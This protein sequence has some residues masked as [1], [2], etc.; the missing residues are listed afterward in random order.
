MKKLF[1]L[2]LLSIAALAHAQNLINDGGDINIAS[3]D[4]I[5]VTGYFNNVNSGSVN[6]SG[7]MEVAGNYTAAG[8]SFQTGVG[9][10]RF[11][12]TSPQTVNLTGEYSFFNMQLDNDSGLHVA[13]DMGIQNLLNFVNGKIYL[14]GHLF[15]IKN[16][17]GADSLRY[18]VCGNGGTVSN[19][20][21]SGP[22][23]DTLFYPIGFTDTTYNP[24]WFQNSGTD[25]YFSV[26]VFNDVLLQGTNGAP[27]TTD[28]HLV[29]RTWVIEEANAG[30]TVPY[31]KVQWNAAHQRPLFNASGNVGISYFIPGSTS[32]SPIAG[33]PA[34]GS[35]PYTVAQTFNPNPQS[36]TA[37]IVADENSAV[38]VNETVFN[39]LSIYPN[40]VNTGNAIQ[41][42]AKALANKNV[43][44]ALY[45]SA[46]QLVFSEKKTVPAEGFMNA[47]L[48]S[49]TSGLYLLTISDGATALY[50]GKVVVN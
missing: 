25:D 15:E 11:N 38:S 6:N 33:V 37:F 47:N 27:N 14:D 45:N 48:P 21:L 31:I 35:N 32:W 26:R 8:N 2:T 43:T 28:Q 22:G 46:G 42:N 39:D 36:M 10:Y 50:R 19:V 12:G 17:T 23:N 41:V 49:V 30:G 20:D 18:F 29:N 1:T 7:V 44:L 9:I 16:F 13:H 4:T 3:G 40:P 24:I 5:T 34:V